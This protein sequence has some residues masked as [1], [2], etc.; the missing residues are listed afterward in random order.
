MIEAEAMGD[1]G[2]TVVSCDEESLM[3]EMPHGLHLIL[4]HRAKRVVN[5]ARASIRLTGIAI[6]SQVRDHDGVVEGESRADLV[7]GDMGL[8]VTVQQQERRAVSFSEDANGSPA[9]LYVLGREPGKK[10]LRHF[11]G[12]GCRCI[13]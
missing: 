9:G 13:R 8:R 1:A 5:V 6:A 4:G 12:W 11:F 7:P 2:A 3:S 10:L